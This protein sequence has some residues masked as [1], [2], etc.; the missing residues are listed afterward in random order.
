MFKIFKTSMIFMFKKQNSKDGCFGFPVKPQ[1]PLVDMLSTFLDKG[2]TFHV[3]SEQG[4]V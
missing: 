3:H 1:Q 4:I 2:Y